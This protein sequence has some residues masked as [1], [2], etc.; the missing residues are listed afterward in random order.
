MDT[1]AIIVKDTQ[2]LQSE[3]QTLVYEN[4][5]K[6]ITATE[7][8]RQMKT[9][10][11]K[12]ENEMK[13][14]QDNMKDI[15]ESSNQ[16]TSV[17]QDTRTNLTNLTEKSNLLKKLSAISSLPAKLTQLVEEKNYAQAVQEYNRSQ[18]IFQL[19]GT[20]P[21]FK[22]IQEDCIKIMDDLRVKLKEDFER[23][24]KKTIQ[25]TQI[26]DL[27]LQLGES[28]SNLSKEILQLTS[29]RLHDELINLQDQT[30]RDMIEFVDLGIENFLSDLIAISSVFYEMFIAKHF[31]SENDS[32]QDIARENLNE[33]VNSNIT[34][35]LNLVHERVDHETESGDCQILL[36]ALDRLNRRL[37][38]MKNVVHGIQVPTTAMDLIIYSIHQFSQKQYKQ[39]KDNFNDNLSSLRL[40]LVTTKNDGSSTNLNQLIDSMYES[41]I[42]KVKNVLQELAIFLN[43]EWSFNIKS[44]HKGMLCVEAIRDNVLIAFLRY[45]SSTMTSFSSI[46]SSSPS[47]LLLVLMKTC[48]KLEKTGVRSLLMFFDELY[49]IE[50][51]SS[52]ALSYE[53]EISSEIYETAK[54]LLDAYVRVQGMTIS[55]MLRKSVETRD[56]I[57]CLEPRSVR[58]V[59]KRVVDDLTAIEGTLDQLFDPEQP[60]TSK[61]SDSSK[62]TQSFIPKQN[63]QQYRSTLSYYTASQQESSANLM[64]RLF[65][66]RVEIFND[67]LDFTKVSVLS[68]II[69]ISLK[70]LLECVRLKS[71]S[72]FGLQQIQVDTHYLQLN[73]WR[74]VADEKYEELFYF[75]ISN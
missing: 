52:S 55:Q 26:G 15:T 41:T 74:F 58:A 21:S 43:P 19:Y 1:E 45:V 25:L 63:M 48:L 53:T 6:F 3:M 24:D 4:Y 75:K 29:Q 66:E 69:K 27:L 38:A 42:E 35:Y 5:N 16:I 44:S 17:L 57:N 73:L 18:W 65:S 7:T 22:G 12:M 46:N 2:T 49:E 9:D 61:S 28:P 72:K 30:E 36:R 39:L 71:F 37:C 13:K 31:E 14:L 62:R 56:W 40:T 8:I 59:M 34:L 54:V 51:E 10:F 20:Q 11:L 67:I 32:F 68:N 64:H 50:S 60:S 33:F 23:A 70:T 47:N